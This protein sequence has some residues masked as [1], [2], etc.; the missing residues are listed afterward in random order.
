[1]GRW[2]RWV[3]L[4]F[5]VAVALPASYIAWSKH[6]QRLA[7]QV[8]D[9]GYEE[10]VKGMRKAYPSGTARVAVEKGLGQRDDDPKTPEMDILLAQDPSIVW[11]CS[12]IDT[13]AV[14][15]FDY[16]EDYEAEPLRSIELDRRGG[17]CL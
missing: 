2:A 4:C 1:M 13:Y 11:Y 6:E 7:Q 5:V 8:R 14:F 15:K 3:V 12:T 9:A 17:G 10:R 16:R